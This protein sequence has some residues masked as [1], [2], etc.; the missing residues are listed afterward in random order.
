MS[1]IHGM[2]LVAVEVPSGD[3]EPEK[4]PHWLSSSTEL[5]RRTS[6]VSGWSLTLESSSRHSPGAIVG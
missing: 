2:A 4:N 6:G 3:H 1:Q 5:M